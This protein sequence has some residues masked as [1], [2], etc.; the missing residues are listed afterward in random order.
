MVKKVELD[1]VLRAPK[2]RF[3]DLQLVLSVRGKVVLEGLVVHKS[4]VMGGEQLL[5]ITLVE[6][7]QV[8][9]PINKIAKVWR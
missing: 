2:D 3:E 1:K 7:E 8:Y 5:D 6:E 4:I 9:T